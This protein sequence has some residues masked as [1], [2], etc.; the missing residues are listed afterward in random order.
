MCGTVCRRNSLPIRS[1]NDGGKPCEPHVCPPLR[2]TGES[3]F[4]TAWNGGYSCWIVAPFQ[5]VAHGKDCG[6]PRAVG[7]FERR[8]PVPY[9]VKYKKIHIE[10]GEEK[11]ERS[12]CVRTLRGVGE[13]GLS[14]FPFRVLLRQCYSFFGTSHSFAV[15]NATLVGPLTLPSPPV[16]S[17]KSELPM[18]II[19]WTLRGRGDHHSRTGNSLN[20]NGTNPWSAVRS[21][22]ELGPACFRRSRRTRSWSPARG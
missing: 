10:G 12:F 20:R 3:H 18:R 19:L 14:P 21:L 22:L 13:R 16:P 4:C 9:P 7:P 17:Y 1:S 15:I 2:L 11:G 6:D 8:Q 5:T